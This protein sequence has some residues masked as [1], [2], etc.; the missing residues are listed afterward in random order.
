MRCIENGFMT[1]EMPSVLAGKSVCSLLEE[2]KRKWDDDILRDIFN[3]RDRQ[4]IKMIPVSSRR[5]HESWFWLHDD[6]GCF[7]VKS[8][9]RLLQGKADATYSQFWKKLWSLK[10]PG[11][12]LNL[13]WRVCNL[14]VPTLTRL[15]SRRIQLDTVCQWCRAQHE[16]NTHVFFGC[17]I[18][19]AVWAD[20]GL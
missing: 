14:C 15:S 11:K 7:T 10:L 16:T 5:E 3:D 20:V 19:T 1:T 2:D 6:K 18:A 12:I 17:S 4:L 9:Y 13:V 8:Y